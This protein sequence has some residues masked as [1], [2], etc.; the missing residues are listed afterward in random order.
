MFTMKQQLISVMKPILVLCSFIIPSIYGVSLRFGRSNII[1]RLGDTIQYRYRPI[2]LPSTIRD[3]VQ[4]GHGLVV[5]HNKGYDF[6]FTFNPKNDSTEVLMRFHEKQKPQL[7]GGASLLSKGVPHGLRLEGNYLYHANNAQRVTKT[8]LDGD[9]VWS[10]DL[11]R[12][13]TLYPMYWPIVPTDAITVPGTDFLLVADGYGSHYVH[14]FNKTN[15]AFI[16][17][18]SFG[19]FGNSTRPLRFHT[20]HS[21]SLDYNSAQEAEPVFIISDRFNHRLVRV[22]VDGT[23]LKITGRNETQTPLPCNVDNS[24]VDSSNGHRMT[25]IPSLGHSSDNLVN[26]SVTILV[27]STVVGKIEIA[28]LLGHQGH[29]H[30]H[31]A[32][33]LP[34]GD[35]VVCCWSGPPNPHQGP[36]L[37][38]ISYWERLATPQPAMT[39][40]NL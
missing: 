26:G 11:S 36:A 7:L 13:K 28:Q 20:P 27:E 34:N 39:T 2:I 31:D 35:L 37:G 29:Q 30:P 16:E 9:I 22:T 1:S 25:A 23:L 38:T 3:N 5:D 19:G 15:G 10:I 32:I 6:Y 4:D 24:Y 40:S 21:I 18:R 33:F 12:W 17:G 14:T 8:D